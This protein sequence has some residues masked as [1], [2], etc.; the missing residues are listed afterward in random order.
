M[1]GQ[2]R[3]NVLSESEYKYRL[4]LCFRR[5]VA[6]FLEFCGYLTHASLCDATNCTFPSSLV[7]G[8]GSW[9]MYDAGHTRPECGHP[10]ESSRQHYCAE[11]AR[12][13]TYSHNIKREPTHAYV[14]ACMLIYKAVSM[15]W[16]TGDERKAENRPPRGC[17]GRA[18]FA[19]SCARTC[20]PISSSSI[21]HVYMKMHDTT[22]SL[23]HRPSAEF[24]VGSMIMG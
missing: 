1:Q 18:I 7:L 21:E 17:W 24:G 13:S 19:R 3:L 10:R 2:S 22:T 14:H 12:S 16:R 4:C 9:R 23:F 8:R 11:C 5:F 20:S 15:D 6:V